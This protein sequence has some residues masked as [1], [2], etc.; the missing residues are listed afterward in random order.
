MKNL[1]I[2]I[3][4]L[5]KIYGN[6]I[7]DKQIEKFLQFI[8]SNLSDKQIP[9]SYW[10]EKD[11]A[12]IIYGDSIK[13]N[14]EKPLITLKKFAQK[15]LSDKIN[16]I[17]ILPFFPYSSDDGF[18][19]IDFEQVNPDLGNWNDIENISEKFNLM[20]D[21]VINHV[22]AKSR[23]FQNYLKGE[24]EGVDYFIEVSP[25]VDLSKVVRP[26][27]LPL[28]TAFDTKQGKKYLWTTFSADQIDLNFS[29]PEVLF[30][31]LQI[32]HLY[33]KKGA[34]IIRLDAI[35]FLWKQIGTTCLHLPQ[36]HEIVKLIRNFADAVAPG[37]IILTETNVPN[38]ENLSYFG[39]NDE[40]HMVYQ[41][42]LPPLLLHAL[43]SG[44]GTYLTN[45]ANELPDLPD[46]CTFFNFTSSH[47][48]IGVRPLEG[49]LP[50]DEK[51]QLFN[52]IKLSGGL[53]S[54]KT[55]SDGTDSPY[56]LNITYFDALK[57]TIKGED[58]LHEQRFICSQAVMLEMKGIPA[59]YIHS[60]LGSSNYYKGVEQTGMARTINREKLQYRELVNELNSNT[61][62][63]RIFSSLL[64]LI[65]LRKQTPAFHPSA[66]QIILNFDAALFAVE[67]I[68]SP[69]EKILCV[70]NLTDNN[71]TVTLPEEYK[72]YNFDIIEE[73]KH[74]ENKI[75]LKPYQTIWLKVI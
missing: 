5:R 33:I 50:D 54:T 25:D 56:E 75:V 4:R 59:F 72:F 53:I 35:A 58:T 27:S 26:R 18:S 23:W 9:G 69:E 31:F 73:K 7:T 37:V 51:Q 6:S 2:F 29:N 13:D 30:K 11:I 57:R 71:K 34:H 17:H 15:Y 24:G 21:L 3:E 28:L 47:D 67:R 48:G 49:L 63:G 20:T 38:K 74:T 68:F 64:N 46:N 62:R 22:S 45:W 66:K 70:N 16:T 55:N 43:Y 41:F 40:A 39:N 14:K 19:V 36:T 65:S 42:S 60:L 1:N 12:L 52:D 10:N 44:N 61:I 8:E 32:L